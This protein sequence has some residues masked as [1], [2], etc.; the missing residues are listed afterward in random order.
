MTRR[1]FY[2]TSH[3]P[4]PSRSDIFCHRGRRRS[5]FRAKRCE[6]GSFHDF[7]SPPPRHPAASGRNGATSGRRRGLPP[8]APLR[9]DA[10][11]LA[12]VI[13]RAAAEVWQ[14]RQVSLPPQSGQWSIMA[15]LLRWSLLTSIA[16]GDLAK[17]AQRP[18]AASRSGTSPPTG[19]LPIGRSCPC[20][21]RSWGACTAG[22]G[23]SWLTLNPCRPLN[24]SSRS[25]SARISGHDRPDSTKSG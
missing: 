10:A 11:R 21:V 8:L 3:V 9:L 13:T 20:W 12:S 16:L 7:S 4:R 19:E 18:C 15:S 1:K 14:C 17:S 5:S 6:F 22:S 23:Q 24:S 25:A 2:S